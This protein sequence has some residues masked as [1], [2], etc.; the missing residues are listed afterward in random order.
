LFSADRAPRSICYLHSINLA[1]I[2]DIERVHH[3]QEHDRL[4]DGPESVP[5]HEDGHE[6][7]RAEQ[8]EEL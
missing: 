6:E 7:L 5:E 2:A 1:P 4:E 8:D 3:E